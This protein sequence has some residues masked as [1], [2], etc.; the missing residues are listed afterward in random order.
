MKFTQIPLIISRVENGEFK[1]PGLCGR[2][3][4]MKKITRLSPE[5]HLW[6]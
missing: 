2:E 5:F 4:V 6:S 1:K 3:F